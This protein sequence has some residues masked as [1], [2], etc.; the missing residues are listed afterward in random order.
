MI[1][2]TIAADRDRLAGAL[3]IFSC[4]TSDGKT[5]CPWAQP[6]D[7]MN[8]LMTSTGQMFRTT[9]ERKYARTYLLFTAPRRLCQR[10]ESAPSAHVERP[11]AAFRDNW[12]DPDPGS[13]V[14]LVVYRPAGQTTNGDPFRSGHGVGDSEAVGA[15]CQRLLYSGFAARQLRRLRE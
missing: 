3:N 2:E 14:E 11:T 7:R 15:G 9:Q 8:K 5:T 4:G 13:P 6:P 12:T 10:T 1:L